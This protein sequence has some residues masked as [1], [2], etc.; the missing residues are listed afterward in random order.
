MAEIEVGKEASNAADAA[1]SAPV[2]VL[3]ES[4]VAWTTAGAHRSIP[5][6]D[7]AIMAVVDR[8]LLLRDVV[9]VKNDD[10]A[11][12]GVWKIIFC[13][14]RVSSTIRDQ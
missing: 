7:P 13:Y 1:V 6:I 5:S 4:T 2:P 14:V 10:G 8:R 3:E 11:C 12:V 9:M